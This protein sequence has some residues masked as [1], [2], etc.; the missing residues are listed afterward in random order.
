MVTGQVTTAGS[1]VKLFDN[2]ARHFKKL[3]IK[4][5]T[6]NTG[7]MAVGN[8][9]V[10]ATS[11]FILDAAEVVTLDI[12]GI[13]SVYIFGAASHTATFVATE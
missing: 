8:S 1:A 9:G 12:S 11:G 5:A 7:D 13:E 3:T 2:S 4:A 6:G 10:T